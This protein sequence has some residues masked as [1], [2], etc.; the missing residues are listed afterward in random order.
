MRRR[1]L[2]VFSRPE[3]VCAI[4]NYPPFRS[5]ARELVESGLD[6][7]AADIAKITHSLTDSAMQAMLTEV[8]EQGG[9][10]AVADVAALRSAVFMAIG[11]N[12]IGRIE[13]R[14]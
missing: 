7:C 12:I 4:V 2:V 6:R 14:V 5:R 11:R 10:I 3:P 13:R 8:G 9:D 1:K